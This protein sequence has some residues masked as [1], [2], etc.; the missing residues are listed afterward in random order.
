MWFREYSIQYGSSVFKFG[1]DVAKGN[2]T[3]KNA[4][5][6]WRV[7][8]DWEVVMTG[9]TEPI[10]LKGSVDIS[11]KLD[12]AAKMS[13]FQDMY[14]FANG[15]KE[16]EGLMPT[17]NTIVSDHNHISKVAMYQ[18]VTN[19]SVRFT[20]KQLF[21]E[22]FTKGMSINADLLNQEQRGLLDYH[23]MLGHFVVP[24]YCT[25]GKAKILSTIVARLHDNDDF[26][27]LCS[28]YFMGHLLS[29]D[30]F[31]KGSGF[32]YTTIEYL[33]CDSSSRMFEHGIE[34]FNHKVLPLNQLTTSV[35]GKDVCINVE[36][37][38]VILVPIKDPFD[39]TVWDNARK[40]VISSINYDSVNY[41]RNNS[42]GSN[43]TYSRLDVIITDKMVELLDS[44]GIPPKLNHT[45]GLELTG[46]LSNP[47][48]RPDIEPITGLEWV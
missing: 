28:G 47:E 30:D 18:V 15:S 19:G 34:L 33:P 14:D 1:M 48:S 10:K 6:T 39:Q 13:N 41:I 44:L 23:G 25:N 16:L 9:I 20:S 17:L 22:A 46:V 42:M 7:V 32:Y 3:P 4:I 43:N 40:G 37:E 36:D 29:K 26:F 8:D 24:I 11:T 38:S 35:V 45:T 21:K 2:T 5:K 27:S 12:T 31:V